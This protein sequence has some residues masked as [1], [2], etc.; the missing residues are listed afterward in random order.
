MC[1]VLD[2]WRADADGDAKTTAERLV[3]TLLAMAK[4]RDEASRNSQQTC[5][6]EV[7]IT[8]PHLLLEVVE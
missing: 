2:R 5:R 7:R 4:I 6:V 8:R 1:W 3:V